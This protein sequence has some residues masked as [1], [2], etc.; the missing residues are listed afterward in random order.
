MKNSLI[1]RTSQDKS[2][3]GVG[4]SMD[5]IR[6]IISSNA[7]NPRC[8]TSIRH[9]QDQTRRHQRFSP[10]SLSHKESQRAQDL[11]THKGRRFF[12]KRTPQTT[13]NQV[14][15]SLLATG[16]QST[17]WIFATGNLVRLM[18]QSARECRFFSATAYT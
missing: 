6:R 1:S 13:P 12:C 17:V 18:T 8:K 11:F 3:L 10:H 2:N 16:L 7:S 15:Y 14:A 4:R 9:G 5:R